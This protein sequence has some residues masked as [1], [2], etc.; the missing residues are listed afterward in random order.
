MDN[1]K[2]VR[3]LLLAVY[4]GSLLK[5][6]KLYKN[7]HPKLSTA[8]CGIIQVFFIVSHAQ[9]FQNTF[10]STR[11]QL[12]PTHPIQDFMLRVMVI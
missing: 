7:I 4:R 10:I 1:F 2:I 9:Y 11:K 6:S 8:L 5:A 3:Y 12:N